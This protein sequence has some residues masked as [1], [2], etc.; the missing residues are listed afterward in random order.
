[1]VRPLW[2]NALGGGPPCLKKKAHRTRTGTSGEE[3]PPDWNIRGAEARDLNIPGRSGPGLE[4]PGLHKEEEAAAARNGKGN[5]NKSQERSRERTRRTR[6]GKREQKERKEKQT[7]TWNL[8]WNSR[9]TN[10]HGLEHP[11]GG[12]PGLELPGKKRP[13]IGACRAAKGGGSSGSKK[14]QGEHEQE[15]G[16]MERGHEEQD[17]EEAT[18]RK[19]PK[20]RNNRVVRTGVSRDEAALDWSVRDRRRGRKQRRRETAKKT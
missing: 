4:L 1:M 16:T 12:G 13:R 9:G 3:T 10:A 11:G 17:P 20:D 18:Q 14:R 5:M 15:P 7:S 8:D 19:P 2:C 6:V